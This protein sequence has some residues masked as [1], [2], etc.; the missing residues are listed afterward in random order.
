MTQQEFD[1]QC[2]E[3]KSRL[4][5]INAGLLAQMQA[6]KAEYKQ[7]IARLIANLEIGDGG[8]RKKHECYALHA[9]LRK[10]LDGCDRIKNWDVANAEIKFNNQGDLLLFE[11]SI[12]PTSNN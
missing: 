1:Q 12:L 4:K 5:T 2:R 3:H 6:N 10:A 8:G 9:H 7:M 11:I